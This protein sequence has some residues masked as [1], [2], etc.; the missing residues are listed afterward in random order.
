MDFPTIN[1][2]ATTRAFRF[3]ARVRYVKLG[4]AGEW[5]PECLKHGIIRLGFGTAKPAR[6]DLCLRGQWAD[7]K[8]SFAAEGK[9]LGTATNF[10]R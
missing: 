9:D 1:A 6:L 5:E 3:D 8:Q 7:L 10:S 2:L 4:H